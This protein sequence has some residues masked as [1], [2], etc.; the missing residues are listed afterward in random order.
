MK[1]KI[2]ARISATVAGVLAAVGTVL[3][4]LMMFFN[5][6][7]E[8]GYF[9]SNILTTILTLC[10]VLGLVAL[11]L[12]SV[13]TDANTVSKK[14]SSTSKPTKTSYAVAA[15]LSLA[16]SIGFAVIFFADNGHK[17]TLT[18]A[19]VGCGI[20][21]AAYFATRYIKE[22]KL[23]QN[24]PALTTAS[25][26]LGL[27]TVVWFILMIG[28]MYFDNYVQMNSPVKT[29]LMFGAVA[30]MLATLADVRY[31]INRALP[32]YTVLMHSLCV[33]T[34]FTASVPTILS[35]LAHKSDDPH[36]PII[37]FS[38]LIFAAVSAFRLKELVSDRNIRR[39]DADDE[40]DLEP[41]AE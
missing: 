6:D 17:K 4:A 36:Y 5:F 26:F 11:M 14:L 16:A 35:S 3:C 37:A 32:R 31:L 38:V 33:F 12:L 2:C 9:K 18:L 21:S 39:E 19:I 20:L 40:L 1:I 8:I 24:E 15:V 7:V 27:G 13:L 30:A 29:L 22:R 10:Y 34:G 25:A 28:Y 41:Y 23:S